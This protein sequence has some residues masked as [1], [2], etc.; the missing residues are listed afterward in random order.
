MNSLVESLKRLYEN[1][2]VSLEKIKEL[3]TH[4]T[5]S[6]DEYNYIIKND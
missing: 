2:K 6:Q 1:K 4:K 3:L 5:I